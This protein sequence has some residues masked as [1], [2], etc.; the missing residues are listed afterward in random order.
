MK[1]FSHI[2]QPVKKFSK[3]MFVILAVKLM[4]FACVF[5]LDSCTKNDHRKS[6]NR[7][8]NTKFLTA[9]EN[10]KAT[11]GSTFLSN[12]ANDQFQNLQIAASTSVTETTNESIPIY[13]DFPSLITPE[14]LTQFGNVNSIQDL[15]AL[16]QNTNAVV[17]YEPTSDNSNYSLGINVNAVVNSLNPL[18]QES[19]QFLY[20]KGLT[21]QDIQQ[22]LSEENAAETDLVPLVM[23]I[24]ENEVSYPIARNY[25]NL[26][27]NSAQAL[28]WS[29][30]GHCAAHALGVDVLFSLGSSGATVWTM[31]AI[32]TAFK[33]VAK[34]MLGPIGV[35][36]AVV[37]FGFCL[38]GVEL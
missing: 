30:V 22:M 27:I 18:I 33:T 16:L 23:V 14:I 6:Y 1:F 29:Q 7:E 26:F 3:G 12:P 10:N 2:L 38:A 21:E 5:I 8:A 13:V 31:G 9:L 19:K 11:V 20:A 28:T 25:S 35:A 36:I 24:T 4:V 32:K 15:S 37:D 17:Q 34:R